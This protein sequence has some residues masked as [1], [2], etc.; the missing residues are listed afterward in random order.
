MLFVSFRFWAI[1]LPLCVLLYFV[2]GKTARGQNIVLLIASVIFYASYDLKYL[3]I[4]ALSIA[5]T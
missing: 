4:L 5:V 3:L 1:L 2:L